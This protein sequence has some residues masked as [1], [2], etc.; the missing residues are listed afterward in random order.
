MILPLLRFLVMAGFYLV[1]PDMSRLAALFHSEVRAGVVTLLFGLQPARMYQAEIIARLKFAGRSVEEELE[2]LVTL[3]LVETT[4]DGN[5]RYYAANRNHPWHAEL[6]GLV[7]KSAGLADVL[8]TALGTERIEFA[9]VFGSVAA[10]IETAESD[11][12]LMVIGRIGLRE[13]APRLR[14]AVGRIGR[15]INAHTFSRSEFKARV[16]SGDHFISGVLAKP[17]L[18]IVGVENE[19]GNLARESVAAPTRN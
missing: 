9:F 6:C 19:F 17:K 18:F 1:L 16:E 8:R 2:K 4:K 14:S 7:L 13:L 15:E 11:V 3:D 12:D 5:R 10:L